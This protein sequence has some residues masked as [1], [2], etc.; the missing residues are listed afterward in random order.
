VPQEPTRAPTHESTH[1]PIDD[2]EFD[3][4]VDPA[5]FKYGIQ[6]PPATSSLLL[7]SKKC[8]CGVQ[9]RAPNGC[10]GNCT[11]ENVTYDESRDTVDQG[12]CSDHSLP[13]P[14]TSSDS[15]ALEKG[16]AEARD[17]P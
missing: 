11:G 2:N 6:Q 10:D 14:P 12:H 9:D 4:P 7:D 13:S 17:T 8:G 16:Q 3:I 1:Q 5:L 15:S